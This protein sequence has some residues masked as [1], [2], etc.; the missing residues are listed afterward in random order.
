MQ[1]SLTQQDQLNNQ[2]LKKQPTLFQNNKTFLLSPPLFQ[3][4]TSTVVRP[5][6]SVFSS[7]LC[8]YS[9]QTSACVIFSLRFRFTRLIV[10]PHALS[11]FRFHLLFFPALADLDRTTRALT[12]TYPFHCPLSYSGLVGSFLCSF[13]SCVVVPVLFPFLDCLFLLPFPFSL[14]DLLHAG[15]ACGRA[16]GGGGSP[17]QC[18][19][20]QAVRIFIWRHSR[21][22]VGGELAAVALAAPVVAAALFLDDAS[23]VIQMPQNNSEISTTFFCIARSR[24]DEK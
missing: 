20:S 24:S 8:S 22:A 2:Q 21:H 3:C 5:P 6:F 15:C 17:S 1:L 19:F 9:Q 4:K 7:C 11:S 12:N 18:A 10:N 14:Q 16:F 13:P 23:F